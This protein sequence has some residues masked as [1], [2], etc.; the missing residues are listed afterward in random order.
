MKALSWPPRRE[1]ISEKSPDGD[2]VR[3]L[4]HQVLEEVG[5]ARDAGRLVGG[6]D[7]IPHVVRDDRR[8]VVGHDHDLQAVGELEL[9]DPAGWPGWRS[10]LRSFG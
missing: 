8:A 4:E 1:T 2:L 3:R 7:A 10:A 6:A 5:D 9:A